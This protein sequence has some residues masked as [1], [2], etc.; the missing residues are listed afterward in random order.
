M[1]QAALVNDTHLYVYGGRFNDVLGDLWELDLLDVE[2]LVVTSDLSNEKSL[3]SSANFAFALL[4]ISVM[5]IFPFVVYVIRKNRE[6]VSLSFS[7]INLF[8]NLKKIAK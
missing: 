7:R 8:I 5:V 4:S 2:L 6:M 3:W 1:H